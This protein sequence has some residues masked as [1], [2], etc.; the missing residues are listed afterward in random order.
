MAETI[1]KLTIEGYKSIHKLEDFELGPLN[2]L[3][4][5]NGAG[6]SNFVGFFGFLREL[7]DQ[8]LQRTVAVGGGADAFLFPGPKKPRGSTEV[9]T[10]AM[11]PI[12]SRWRPRRKDDSSSRKR[13]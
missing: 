2:V 8:R 3:I 12:D 13:T 6:K 1:K 10:S 7:V 4:G 9:S 11:T 5:A